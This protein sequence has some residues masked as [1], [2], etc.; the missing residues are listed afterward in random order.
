MRTFGNKNNSTQKDPNLYTQVEIA[1]RKMKTIGTKK[2]KT[3]YNQCK[4]N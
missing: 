3:F 1:L 2:M 4:R